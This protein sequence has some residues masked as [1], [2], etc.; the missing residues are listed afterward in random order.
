MEDR[1]LKYSEEYI[2]TKI[3]N[4][5]RDFDDQVDSL[6]RNHEM[7]Q[8]KW[9]NNSGLTDALEAAYHE[10]LAQL[11]KSFNKKVEELQGD[12]DSLV[13]VNSQHIRRHLGNLESM[14]RD[15]F[16]MINRS[17]FLLLCAISLRKL[18]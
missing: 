1:S 5:K 8:T 3:E 2:K 9:R 13:R 16:L 7:A 10:E 15:L 18:F 4:I 11:K 14:V 17:T 12:V 6:H